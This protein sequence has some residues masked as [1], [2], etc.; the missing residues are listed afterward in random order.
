MFAAGVLLYKTFPWTL[1]V[2]AAG[3]TFSTPVSGCAAL[4][5]E[6]VDLVPAWQPEKASA[7]T[8]HIMHSPTENHFRDD[9]IRNLTLGLDYDQR[10]RML[11][12]TD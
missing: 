5:V 11:R 3:F 1:P 10:R 4:F 8:T 12:T 2:P 6:L 7:A 9:M